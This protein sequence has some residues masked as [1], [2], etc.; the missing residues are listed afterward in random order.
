[1]KQHVKSLVCSL[2]LLLLL[3]KWCRSYP[4]ILPHRLPVV[5]STCGVSRHPRCPD[6]ASAARPATQQHP[7]TIPLSNTR[8]PHCK[9]QSIRASDSWLKGVC[10]FLFAR[11]H[12]RVQFMCVR[13]VGQLWRA[14]VDLIFNYMMEHLWG[15]TDGAVKPLHALKVRAMV[16]L[17]F[18]MRWPRGGGQRGQ[19]STEGWGSGMVQM[20]LKDEDNAER[21]RRHFAMLNLLCGV[22]GKTFE[23]AN[24]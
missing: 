18:I 6:L 17:A 15:E 11:M 5:S 9:L 20:W 16:N 22:G 2:F 13:R 19:C 12:L 23:K 1:M 7:N 8:L 14:P 3:I 4:G 10:M 24:I 21:Q